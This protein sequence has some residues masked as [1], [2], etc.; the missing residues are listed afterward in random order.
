M[1]T[2]LRHHTLWLIGALLLILTP[3]LQGQTKQALDLETVTYGGKSFRSDFYP[4]PVY[5]LTWLQSGYTYTVEGGDYRSLRVYTPTRG[6]EQTVLTQDELV[7]LLKPYDDTDKL[8]PLIAYDFT[9]QCHYLEVEL[10]KGL[11]LIDVEQKLIVGYF[12]TG[13][14]E[15]RASLLS[16]NERNLAVKSLSLIH[17]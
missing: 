7:Q 3:A 15:K 11:Y 6:Q 9:P 13:D 4:Q 5:G 10:T 17:I 8:Y 2:T 16:P 1:T 14:T 12:A